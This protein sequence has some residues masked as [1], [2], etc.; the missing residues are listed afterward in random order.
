[1]GIVFLARE[2]AL[3]RLVAPKL[4]PPEMAARPGVKERFLKWREERS[5]IGSAIA[6]RFRI[7]MR[8]VCCVR[9]PGPWGMRTST[10]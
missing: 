6:D 3:D 7:P 5:E 4:L 8:S 10:A 9:S 1:M 2:V